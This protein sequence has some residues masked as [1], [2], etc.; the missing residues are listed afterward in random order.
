MV[1]EGPIKCTLLLEDPTK[2]KDVKIRLEHED[3]NPV[4]LSEFVDIGRTRWPHHWPEEVIK[5]CTWS[6]KN[7]SSDIASMYWQQRCM[8]ATFRTFSLIIKAKYHFIKN[9]GF[10]TTFLNEFTHDL[11]VF[12]NRASVLA[13]AYL[14]HPSN[15]DTIN[16]LTQWNDNHFFTPFGDSLPAYLVDKEH[17]TEGQTNSRGELVT[18]ATQPLLEIDMHE[19]YHNHG[20]YHDDDFDSMLYP[21]VKPGY[22][23]HRKWFPDGTNTKGTVR[24]ESFLWWGDDVTRLQEDYEARFLPGWIRNILQKRR[25]NGRFVDDILY[26]IVV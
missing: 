3:G 19:K 24:K 1:Y 13:Q 17:Y 12:N 4:S 5:D 21:I 23:T 9:P 10:R 26:R 8:T 22:N 6:F 20:E 2:P 25:L 18:L 11:S 16:G 14:F 15:P 7:Y